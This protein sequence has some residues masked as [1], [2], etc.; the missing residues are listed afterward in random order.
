MSVDDPKPPGDGP[1]ETAP[2]EPTIRR[3]WRYFSRRHAFLAGL[4]IGV[5]ILALLLLAFILYRF[6]YIDRYVAG[7]ITDTFSK[8]GIRATIKEFHSSIP[9][10]TVEMSGIELFDSA[11]GAKLGKIDHLSAKIRIEDL[12]ALNLRRN[13]NLEDLTIDGFEAWVAFDEQGQSNFRNIHIPAPEPNARILFAYSTAHVQIRNGV[14]HYGDAKHEISGE[15]RNLQATVQPDDPSAPV[16][17]RMN[18][19]TLSLTDSTFTY[20]GRPIDKID[21]NARGRVNQTRAEIQELI[22][23]SPVTETHLS[24]TMDDWRALRYQMNITSSVDLT[25]VSDTFE[26]NPTLRGIGNFTGTVNGEG[27]RFTIQGG[28]KSD[29]LAADGVRLQGLNV[30]ANGKVQGKTYEI[31]GKAVADLLS[32]GDFQ[33]DA[34]QLAGNVMGTGTNFRW[35]GE[36]R[37][38]AAKG[39]GTSMTGL[40]L[41][42]ARAEMNK[43]VLTASA[44][45]FNA[46]ALTASGAKVEGVTASDLRVRNQNK[47]TTATVASVKAGDISASGATVKGVTASNVDITDREGVTSVVVKNVQIGATSTAGAEIGALNIAGVKLSVRNRRVEGSTADIDAGNMKVADGEVDKVKLTHPVFI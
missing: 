40:I 31:N 28:V 46:N 24:G 11:T 30:T 25:E 32:S 47:V 17:S 20:D 34:L 21:L 29:D 36:L 18:T 3:R 2:Q 12:Y 14:V 41:R 27:E 44:S 13:I 19:V 37:A 10:R 6:G 1:K 15:A 26:T 4:I 45:Q 38:V 7:Q 35:I 8:Y 9:P 39:Y 22:L 43:Q 5:G 16:S 42:D 23:K 33:I